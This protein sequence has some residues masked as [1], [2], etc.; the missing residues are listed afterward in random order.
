[1]VPLLGTEPLL[2]TCSGVPARRAQ[3][4]CSGP[5]V[6]HAPPGGYVTTGT[7]QPG[8]VYMADSWQLAVEALIPINAAS[9]RNVGVVGQID[10]FLDDMFPNSFIGKPIFGGH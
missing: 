1:M 10:I 5:A 7:V 3:P 6:S 8:V 9:G 2:A 4:G